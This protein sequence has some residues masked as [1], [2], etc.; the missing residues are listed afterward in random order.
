MDRLGL[1]RNKYKGLPII[2]A[3]N[4]NVA[5]HE[6]T[7]CWIWIGSR[8][9]VGYG[10]M[11]YEGGISR[12]AHRLAYELFVGEI[13]DELYVCHSCDNRTC[14]NPAHLFLGTAQDNMLDMKDKGR[15][16]NQHKGK[17]HCVNGHLLSGENVRLNVN[18]NQRVCKTC[19]KRNRV[20][21]QARRRAKYL[22]EIAKKVDQK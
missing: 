4:L 10:R 8:E 21:F 18:S 20:N 12:K 15:A 1:K 2:E 5:K 22:K 11:R 16:K 6:D 13:T 7:A 3:F 19:E 14:V 17:T 9:T